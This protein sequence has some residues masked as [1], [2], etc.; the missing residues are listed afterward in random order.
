[1]CTWT[2]PV[3]VTKSKPEWVVSVSYLFV[4]SCASV[5]A[6]LQC[7]WWSALRC[8]SLQNRFKCRVGATSR[9][10]FLPHCSSQPCDKKEWT[11]IIVT[12]P[13]TVQRKIS[14][15]LN[16]GCC[17]VSKILM[18]LRSP[19]CIPHVSLIR[20][21]RSLLAS[22]LFPLRVLYCK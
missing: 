6:E 17:S 3:W 16:K 11:Q 10:A 21:L 13:L 9:S 14:K 4:K 22:S 2:V 20:P 8:L 19:T 18:F 12:F 5:P 7:S 15:N 1:M